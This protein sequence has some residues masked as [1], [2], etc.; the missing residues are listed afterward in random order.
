[1]S[2]RPSDIKSDRP[3][4]SW[5]DDLEDWL[6][7]LY[8]YVESQGEQVRD[9]YLRK[10]AAKRLGSRLTRYTAVVLS[11]IAGLLPIVVALLL[12]PN[13]PQVSQSGLVVSLLIGVA[14]ALVALDQFGGYSTGWI[15]YIKAAQLIDG[16]L[17][18]FRLQWASRV[19]Q[20]RPAAAPP[21]PPQGSETPKQ[22]LTSEQ[23]QDHIQLA[24]DFLAR[25]QQLIIA[26]TAEWVSEF[27]SNLSRLDSELQTRMKEQRQ[28]TEEGLERLQ[29]GHLFIV[30]ENLG[31]VDDRKLQVELTAST[32]VVVDEK[33]LEGED[34]YAVMN[35]AAGTYVVV[36]SGLRQGAKFTTRR[37][38]E[39]KSAQ[40]CDLVID[41]A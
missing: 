33:V 40:R 4:L 14:A 30:F 18:D 6:S 38:F 37:M 8:N 28:T 17:Q 22:A 36:V 25:L 35:L 23:L 32:G 5:G 9:W 20:S 7:R 26:E 34:S 21:P 12:P 39:V 29:P 2:N 10:K 11:G 24:R 31:G 15:R 16:A 1:M 13:G 19:A 41:L 27:Q 3:D